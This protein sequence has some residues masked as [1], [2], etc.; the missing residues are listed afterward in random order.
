MIPEQECGLAAV[1]FFKSVDN[2]LMR[3]RDFAQVL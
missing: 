1:S 3:F 2:R